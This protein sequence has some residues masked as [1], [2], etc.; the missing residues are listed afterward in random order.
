MKKIILL[1]EANGVKKTFFNLENYK[2]KEFISTNRGNIK[3]SDIHSVE[4][5]EIVYTHKNYPYRVTPVSIRDYI[6]YGIKRNTQIIYPKD[7]AYIS[8]MLG[9]KS[10]DKVFE[11]GTGSGALTMFIANIVAE[12]G[13]VFTYEKREKFLEIA[14]KNIKIMNLEDY[15]VFNLKDLEKEKIGENNFDAAFI[16]V[17][18]PWKLIPSIKN[19]LKNGKKIGILVPTTNQISEV[20]KILNKGFYNVCIQEILLREY[21]TNPERIRPED[22]MVAHTGYLI[23]ANKGE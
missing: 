15:V 10:G 1:V 3:I 17:K 13:K 21:K 11:C 12:K 4:W 20:L 14:K 8:Y 16:D 23:F 19:V 5:G 18:E 2:D 9:L 22:R 7:A 6:I